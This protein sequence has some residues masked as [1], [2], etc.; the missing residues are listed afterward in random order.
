MTFPATFRS[1]FM[2][3]FCAFA[4]PATSFPKFASLIL[5]VV[6]AFLGGFPLPTV[7]VSL[8][9]MYQDSVTSELFFTSKAKMALHWAM[10][11]R[12][13]DSEVER[14][15]EIWS[16]AAEEGWESELEGQRR[17]CCAEA[18]RGCDMRVA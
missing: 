10:A 5:S 14:A 7:P 8:R 1:P 4:L 2:N 16:K 9:S 15:A 12:R 13:L 11:S 6:V 18:R 17:V 3:K